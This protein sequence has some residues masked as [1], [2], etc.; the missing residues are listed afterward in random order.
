LDGWDDLT[1][2]H[3]QLV[4]LLSRRLEVVHQHLPRDLQAALLHPLCEL[5]LADALQDGLG[6]WDAFLDCVGV[7]A[8]GEEVVEEQ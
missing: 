1:A 5:G 6:D 3:T 7:A 8:Q 2:V 4:L